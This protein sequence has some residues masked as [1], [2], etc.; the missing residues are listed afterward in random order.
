MLDDLHRQWPEIV[1]AT[2]ETG[3][4]TTWATVR[5]AVPTGV[6]EVLVARG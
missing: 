6:G 4:F 2:G 3:T 1:V 5:A